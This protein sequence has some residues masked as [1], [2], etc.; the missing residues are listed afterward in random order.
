MQPLT[1][2]G[3]DSGYFFTR[4]NN[5]TNKCSITK[6]LQVRRADPTLKVNRL[7]TP[8]EFAKHF[9]IG[10]CTIDLHPEVVFMPSSA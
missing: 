8:H 10:S 5:A 9:K 4:K 1:Y 7:N 6:G 3:N 2:N